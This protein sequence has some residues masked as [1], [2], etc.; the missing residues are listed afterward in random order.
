MD[1]IPGTPLTLVDLHGHRWILRFYDFG[2]PEQNALFALCEEDEDLAYSLPTD[3][4]QT[5]ETLRTA[6]RSFYLAYGTEWEKERAEADDIEAPR[7]PEY[8]IASDSDFV[9]S[10]TGSDLR[11][12][13]RVAFASLDGLDSEECE[14]LDISPAYAA[15]LRKHATEIIDQT[16]AEERG[17]SEEEEQ[18]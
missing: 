16:L 12:L 9:G 17:I 4:P 6:V 7:S 8:A 3:A 10:I 13:L 11:A 15:R 14:A 1:E 2:S 18:G 5:A